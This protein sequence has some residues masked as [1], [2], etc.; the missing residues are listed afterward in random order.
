MFDDFY[1]NSGSFVPTNFIWEALS[2]LPDVNVNSKDFKDLLIRLYQNINLMILALNSKDSGYY[3]PNEFLVGSLL[4]P[5]ANASSSDSP[6][7]RQIFRVAVNCGP[8]PNTATASTPHG[9]P[10]TNTYTVIK[11]YGAATDQT[12]LTYIPL[13][14]VSTTGDAIEVNLDATNINITTQS[15]RT[16]YTLAYV[17]IE[18][19]K[20]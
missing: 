4:F 17:I 5:N 8:L 2:Q 3:N 12:G 6:Q 20:N 15:D 14:Y 9:I 11:I 7:W 1:I 13:P 10:F 19:V 16:N 18:Y